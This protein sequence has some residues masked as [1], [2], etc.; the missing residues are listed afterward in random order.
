MSEA[1]LLRDILAA[2][3]SRPGVQAW[4]TAAIGCHLPDGRGGW[5]PVWPLPP[6]WP[7]VTAIVHGRALAVEVKS[8]RLR[9]RD[10]TAPLRASQAAVR[11]AWLAAGGVW[12]TATSV[13]EVVEAVEAL[14]AP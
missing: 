1:D 12:V 7:D 4:R 6:G 2:I 10:G 8:P 9:R 13:A 5:R 3:G 14:E 11:D